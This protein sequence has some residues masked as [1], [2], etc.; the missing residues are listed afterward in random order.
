MT[1]TAALTVSIG[2]LAVADT[3]LTATIL[4]VPVWVTFI[5]WASFFACGGGLNGLVKSVA[6]NITGLVIAS[7]TL[8]AIA[9]TSDHPVVAAIWVGIGS[10]AM[11]VA[12]LVP[13][14]S[15]P[16]AIVFGFASTVGTVAAT[17]HPITTPGL[18]NP[19]L[20][21]ATAIVV[22]GLFGLVS[23]VFA[24]ALTTKAATSSA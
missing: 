22:G 11:I 5:A 16:P 4:P 7:A 13:L 9:L 24:N 20:I 1:K 23:E 10:A 18:G 14:L 6:S 2:L 3:Y 15:F 17:G 19:A 8:I 21:A 12:T